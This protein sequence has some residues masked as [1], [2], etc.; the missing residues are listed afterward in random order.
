M[1][2]ADD[3][4]DAPAS[5]VFIHKN[6]T[7]M[8]RPWLKAFETAPNQMLSSYGLAKFSVMSDEKYRKT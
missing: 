6:Q 7:G 8:K 2:H 4:A 5:T 3:F 1:V